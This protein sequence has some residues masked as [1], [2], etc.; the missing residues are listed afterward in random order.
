ML[1]TYLEAMDER[2]ADFHGNTA[3]LVQALVH[4]DLHGFAQ[5]HATRQRKLP[6]SLQ[7][8]NASAAFHGAPISELERNLCPNIV[9]PP[10]S[11][12]SSIIKRTFSSG[13]VVPDGN[14]S[15]TA[16]TA[17]DSS[18]TVTL[19]NLD[20]LPQPRPPQRQPASLIGKPLLLFN[21]MSNQYQSGRIVDERDY[22]YYTIIMNNKDERKRDGSI[23]DNGVSSSDDNVDQSSSSIVH[24]DSTNKED[25]DGKEQGMAS[26]KQYLI[27]FPAG[28]LGGGKVDFYHWIF[29]EEHAINLGYCIIWAQ[30]HRKRGTFGFFAVGR[31]NPVPRFLCA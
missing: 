31:R 7:T 9:A 10:S 3:R 29:L 15:N 28:K 19:S 8:K 1:Q 6:K 21:P 18:A 26:C 20:T 24:G 16:A 4:E 23:T 2:R 30:R 22:Y 17:I 5:L 13:N 25:V 11:S 12:S 14:D 27:H